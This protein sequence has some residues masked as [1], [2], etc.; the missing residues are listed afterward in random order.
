LGRLFQ[1]GK[2][3]LDLVPLCAELAK[4]NLDFVLTVIGD[5]PDRKPL[6]LGLNSVPG[7]AD[8]VRFM[9]WMA[10]RDA[11][12]LL[13][14]QHVLVM[15]S[16][17]EGQPIAML[18]AMGAGLV[19]LVTDISAFHEVIEDGKNG[20]LLPVGGSQQFAAVLAE[21]EANRER[22]A[23]IA[24][25]AWQRVRDTWETGVAISKLSNLLHDVVNRPVARD[26]ALGSIS[27]PM[28]R[29]TQLGV[30]HAVQG[31]KRRILRQDVVF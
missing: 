7:I 18:E 5:G 16:D 27:Y 6:E 29:M 24:E 23:R 15:L 30:P 26:G 12:Q 8:R 28:S 25:A 11:V 20:F 21:L 2:R 10:N 4:R 17:L 1:H 3:I 13:K 31:I 19:P 9:G 14:E 22:L